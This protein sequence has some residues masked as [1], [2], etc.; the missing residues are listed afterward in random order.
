MLG[1]EIRNYE[2]GGLRVLI[3]R[4]IGLTYAAQEKKRAGGGPS[5]AELWD[6]APEPVRRARDFRRLGESHRSRRLG[7][8]EEPALCVDAVDQRAEHPVSRL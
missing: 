8:G 6:L 3:P 4:A 5:I 1:I 2:G 7:P